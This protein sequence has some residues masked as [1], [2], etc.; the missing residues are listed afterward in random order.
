M[1]CDEISAFFKY[2]KVKHELLNQ[3]QRE[4]NIDAKSLHRRVVLSFAYTLL[5]HLTLDK[6]TLPPTLDL[7]SHVLGDTRVL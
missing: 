6:L 7:R 5:S 2:V 3:G 1:N 4:Y